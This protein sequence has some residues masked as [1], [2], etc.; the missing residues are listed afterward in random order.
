MQWLKFWW[1]DGDVG[2]D[3]QVTYGFPRCEPYLQDFCILLSL[4]LELYNYDVS[5]INVQMTGN[6]LEWFLFIFYLFLFL[7]FVFWLS[8]NDSQTILILKLS[9]ACR[10]L[11]SI[12]FDYWNHT[13]SLPDRYRFSTCC[14]AIHGFG[15]HDGW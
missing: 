2:K 3:E 5:W 10:L 14:V 8:P 11:K 6:G 13:C 9:P 1:V 7:K 4:V 15:W 12:N